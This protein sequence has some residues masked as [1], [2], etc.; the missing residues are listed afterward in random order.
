MREPNALQQVAEFHTLFQHPIVSTPAI[1]ENSR[2]QLRHE[3]LHEEVKELKSA[4]EERNLVEI[5][6]ALCDIQYV[7]AGAVLEF[8]MGDIFKNLFDEVHRSNMSKACQTEAEAQETVA[9][10]AKEK[11]TNAYY[12]AVDGLYMVYR[13]E[14][15]KTLKSIAY[16]PA[17]LSKF[18]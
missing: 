11:N 3:L 7:L 2:A 12:K 6:D 13:S 15:H 18:L 10:Y 8:G 1:P 5:A 14:D 9:W 4:I 16:Q 17:N